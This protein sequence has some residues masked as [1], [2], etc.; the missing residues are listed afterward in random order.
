MIL[1]KKAISNIILITFIAVEITIA[2][3]VAVTTGLSVS[4]SNLISGNKTAE[5]TQKALLSLNQNEVENLIQREKGRLHAEPLSLTTLSNIALLES[6]LGKSDLATDFSLEAA[7]RSLRDPYT[8]LSA[9]QSYL[10]KNDFP[11][12][13]LHI[14]ALLSSQPQLGVRIFPFI[15]PLLDNP[16]VPPVLAK[17]LVSEPPWRKSFINWLAEDDVTGQRT[18]ALLSAIKQTGGSVATA[19][20][21]AMIGKQINLKNFDQAYFYWLDSLDISELAHVGNIYDGRFTLEPGNQFFDWNILPAPNV[22][23]T[24]VPATDKTQGREL[25][26]TF[27]NNLETYGHVFQYLHLSPGSYVVSG[28]WSAPS[29]VTSGGL[30]WRLSCVETAASI[31]NSKTFLTPSSTESFDF[32]FLIPESDC[33]FQVLRLAAASTAILDAKIDGELRFGQLRIEPTK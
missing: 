6:L 32:T 24:I 2:L 13:F 3:I 21:R 11:E 7:N 17:T 29:L 19:E 18:F 14:D 1:A 4:K 16:A 12:A 33:D 22:D 31:G 26:I 23:T 5:E 25:H 28:N 20:T 10:Q 9:A 15:G 30:L 8:Q 27:L